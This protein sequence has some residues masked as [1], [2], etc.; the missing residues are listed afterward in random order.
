MLSGYVSKVIRYLIYFTL[1]Y[2][3]CLIIHITNQLLFYFPTTTTV[4]LL[5]LPLAMLLPLPLDGR[6][7]SRNF[8]EKSILARSKRA[9][10]TV[11]SPFS[12]DCSS[13]LL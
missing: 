2:S 10:Y 3:D 1:P 13:L 6:N 7:T 12:I 8:L 4:M 9:K 11:Q 5:Q